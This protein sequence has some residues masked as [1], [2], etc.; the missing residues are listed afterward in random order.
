MNRT[1]CLYCEQRGVHTELVSTGYGGVCPVCPH[2]RPFL[3]WLLSWV[4]QIR[5]KLLNVGNPTR[6]PM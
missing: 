6:R 2:A 4:P 5:P 3:D 1:T